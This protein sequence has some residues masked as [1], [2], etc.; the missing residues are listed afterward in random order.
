MIAM[1]RKM[2]E[3]QHQSKQS[4]LYSAAGI[5]RKHQGLSLE[6]HLG[7]IVLRQLMGKTLSTKFRETNWK[8]DKYQLNPMKDTEVSAFE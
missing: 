3:A 6:F 8:M 2:S 1:M 5:M 7:I 4:I